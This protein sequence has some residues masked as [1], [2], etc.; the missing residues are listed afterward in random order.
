MR[1]LRTNN[2]KEDPSFSFE[3]SATRSFLPPPIKYAEEYRRQFYFFTILQ[4]KIIIVFFNLSRIQW[5]QRTFVF[6][7][8]FIPSR[9][10]DEEMIDGGGSRSQLCPKVK[11]WRI[12]VSSRGKIYEDHLRRPRPNTYVTA[13]PPSPLWIMVHGWKSKGGPTRQVHRSAYHIMYRERERERKKNT[14][15]RRDVRAPTNHGRGNK[16]RGEA[17]GGRKKRKGRKEKKGKEKGKSWRVRTGP[18]IGIGGR[19]SGCTAS[20]RAKQQHWR[21]DGTRLPWR[22][23]STRAPPLW[24]ATRRPTW[25]EEKEPGRRTRGKEEEGKVIRRARRLR[26]TESRG[27]PERRGELRGGELGESR[28]RRKRMID[29]RATTE[30]MECPAMK[31]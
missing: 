11:S 1:H 23:P 25:P 29:K 2:E 26:G 16:E 27:G 19:S 8:S 22:G 17:R 30:P 9:L 10:R 28:E 21:T 15:M 13:A 18:K 6:T 5:K 3:S 4:P 31:N 7:F 24:N 12:F 14:S 20:K